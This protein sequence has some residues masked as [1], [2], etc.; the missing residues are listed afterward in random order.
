[1][2]GTISRR[3]HWLDDVLLPAAALVAYAAWVHP[4]FVP[5]LT[6]PASGARA[7]GFTL[8][9]CLGLLAAGL[10]AGRLARQVRWGW[11]VVIGGG[12]AAC[13]GLL[14][15]AAPGGPR[16]WIAGALA[17]PGAIG[18]IVCAALLWWRG[19]RTAQPDHQHETG[20]TFAIGAT[21]LAGSAFVRHLYA[22]S[23]TEWGNLSLVWASLLLLFGVM[24]LVAALLSMFYRLE[25]G[26]M[27]SGG[28]AVVAWSALLAS[29]TRPVLPPTGQLS[30]PI[31]L[32]GFAG[33]VMRSLIGLSWVL[34][35]QRD[36]EGLR[37]R[38]DG[39]WLAVVLALAGGVIVAGVLA[40]QWL[41][42]GAVATMLR[43][44]GTAF[45]FVALLVGMVVTFIG[46]LIGRLVQRLF[47]NLEIQFPELPDLS[48]DDVEGIGE[49]AA[50]LSPAARQMT[51]IVLVALIGALLAWVLYRTARRLRAAGEAYGGADEARRGML[52]WD[53]IRAQVR[54]GLD[55]LRRGSRA[56]FA[57]VSEVQGARRAI[58]RAYRRV[59]A[60]AARAHDETP[61]RYRDRLGDAYPAERSDLETLTA[62]YEAARYGVEPPSTAEA[63]AAQEAAERVEA[64]LGTGAPDA[65]SPRDA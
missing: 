5:Y 4:L 32:F 42:P 22:T 62:A 6:D 40:G 41:T 37:I 39:S 46:W 47:P 34:N 2:R 59:L 49:G 43:W 28:E 17:T 53:L 14:W 8:W 10:A 11:A 12:L 38:I 33:L 44:L 15:V 9:L 55:R 50:N 21:A 48:P 19:V 23:G 60:R 20:R 51:G 64:A 1:M 24:V 16:A 63:R 58:R 13:L 36:R 26:V 54:R 57:P 27:A 7:P 18:G 45:L 56:D 35:N 30:G 65:K 3:W 29:T 52:S 61:E 25:P 31:V